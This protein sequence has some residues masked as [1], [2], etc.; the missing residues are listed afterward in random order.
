MSIEKIRMNPYALSLTV[1]GFNLSQKEGTGSFVA[2][3]RLY[4][5][6]EGQSLFRRAL[7]LSSLSL[8]GPSVEFTHRDDGSFSFS[9]LLSSPKAETAPPEKASE[10]FLFSINNI[11]IERG[12]ILRNN[13]V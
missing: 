4:L 6:L 3:D 7:I 9:D 12:H 5:N 11:E 10:P 2:F 8:E 13:F 1:E